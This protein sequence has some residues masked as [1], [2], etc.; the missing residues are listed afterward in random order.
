MCMRIEEG[1]RLKQSK[2][3]REVAIDIEWSHVCPLHRWLPLTFSSRTRWNEQ[4]HTFIQDRASQPVYMRKQV[5]LQRSTSL[6]TLSIRLLSG[7][8]RHPLKAPS[9]YRRGL[10]LL[11]TIVF[12][13]NV[14][15]YAEWVR[16]AQDYRL[17]G[18][19]TVYVDPDMTRREGNLVTI[20]QLTDFKWMQGSARGPAR[21]SST[22]TQ[23]QF[24]CTERRV[25]LLAYMEFS[26]Q[27]EAGI[28][29]DGYVDKNKWLPVEPDSP[30]YALWQL[31]CG[32]E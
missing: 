15:A 28:R 20:W 30:N 23:K 13:S 21:F 6:S 19:Q 17:P 24:D 1:D 25:R 29:V 2:R 7:M 9:V 14:P 27:M 31:A 3:V 16:V 4:S 11:I 5:S 18:F 8:I 10:W 22:K 32:K 12:M 26:L